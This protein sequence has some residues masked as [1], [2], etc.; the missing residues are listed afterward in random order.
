MGFSGT[1][2]HFNDFGVHGQVEPS[3]PATPYPGSMS[4]NKS[5]T[6]ADH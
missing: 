2:A 3:L 4:A 5:E 1:S 6:Q